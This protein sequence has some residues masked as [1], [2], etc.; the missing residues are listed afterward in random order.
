M[1]QLK[2]NGVISEITAGNNFEYVIQDNSDFANTDYKVLQN[3][4]SGIFVQCVKMTRNGHVD[5]LYLTESYRPLTSMISDINADILLNIFTNLFADVIEIKNNGFLVCQSVDL[6]WDKVFVDNNTGKVKLIYLPL[7]EKIFDS[8]PEFE[9]DLRSRTVQL[10]NA[11]SFG[12]NDR[13]QKFVHDLSD[14]S[15]T[16]EDVY[17]NNINSNQM[18]VEAAK[19]VIP[20]KAV[21]GMLVGIKLVAMNISDHFEIAIDGPDVVIGKKQELVDIVIPFNKMISRRHCRIIS[22]NG[23]YFIVDEGSANGTFVNGNKLISGEK[24]PIKRGDV[25]RLADSDFQVI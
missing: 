2:E 13:V 4:N 5:L 18:V 24:A 9:T 10:I 19:V 22:V 23:D 14:G 6:N 17:A 25:I 11:F 12:N 8:Y 21:T 15:L 1:N 16:I 7:K 20:N 3:Q